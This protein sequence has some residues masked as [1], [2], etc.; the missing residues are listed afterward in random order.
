MQRSTPLHLALSNNHVEAAKA[1]INNGADINQAE[2]HDQKTW[3]GYA[4]LSLTIQR[5][6][7]ACACLLVENGAD[8]HHKGPMSG[9][10]PLH[11]AIQCGNA[12]L[13]R[14]LLVHGAD[15]HAQDNKRET[16]LHMAFARSGSPSAMIELLT[17]YTHTHN[18]DVN[19]PLVFE[20]HR[21]SG[22][23]LHVAVSLCS[24][25]LTHILLE[26]GAHVNARTWGDNTALHIIAADKRPTAVDIAHLLVVYGA[27]VNSVNQSGYLEREGKTP[28][29]I[30]Q[31]NNNTHMI[32]F[33]AS[34]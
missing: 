21:A 25:E 2:L 17:H 28:L 13:V 15:I 22:K 3:E 18:V 1:L 20:A 19:R 4:P 8:V 32:E 23:L 27:L 33:L 14:T 6:K 12:D 9:R 11:Y 29:R 34:L 10:T 7:H 26:K 31:E 24:L 16:P 5:H 30:A